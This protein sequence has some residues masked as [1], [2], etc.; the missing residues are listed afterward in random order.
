MREQVRRIFA[1]L[2]AEWCREH[3]LKGQIDEID[4]ETD[5][6]TKTA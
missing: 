5:S 6:E 2:L 4:T 3:G 1:A